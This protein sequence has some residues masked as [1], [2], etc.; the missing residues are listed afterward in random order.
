MLIASLGFALMQLSVKFLNHL[1]ATEIVLLRSIF[2]FVLTVFLLRRA[3]VSIW[4]NNKKVLF[5]RGVFG[6]IALTLFFFTIQNAPL[7]SATTV[8]YLSPIFTVIFAIFLV[9]EK[10][11]W[12]QWVF[13]AVAFAGVVMVKGFDPNMP[14]KYMF[15]GIGAALSSGI[16]YNCIRMVKDTDHPLVVVLYFPIVAI[17]VMIVFSF[18]EWIPPAG[19]D[20]LWILACGVFTQVGQVFMTKAFH[21]ENIAVVSIVRYLGIIYALSFGFLFF[22]ETYSLWSLVGMGLVIGG[23]IANL[24]VT[25]RKKASKEVASVKD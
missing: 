6:T 13:F 20:W 14:W 24:M 22:G 10:V 9:G 25:R 2:S 21:A 1:P 7:A 23:V 5:L 15:F 8:M 3:N 17:P 11:K 4:G 12:L 16:A 19:I 18:F